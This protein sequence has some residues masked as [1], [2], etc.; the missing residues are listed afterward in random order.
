MSEEVKV[1]AIMRDIRGQILARKAAE[2]SETAAR[3]P[4]QGN[5]LPPDF[6]EHLYQAEMG[7]D[8]LQVRANVQPSTLPLIGGLVTR[9]KHELHRL[10]IYYVNQLAEKQVEVNRQLLKALAILAETVE[11]DAQQE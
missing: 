10:V 7:Y 8:Q 5:L 4:L 1:E 2:G 9:L 6:Y 3:I 11:A